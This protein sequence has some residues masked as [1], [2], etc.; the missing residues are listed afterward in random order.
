MW[1]LARAVL[2]PRGWPG[3]PSP[4][5]HPVCLRVRVLG[6]GL[7]PAFL[8]DA[9]GPGVPGLPGPRAGYGLLEYVYPTGR[10]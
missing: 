9:L 1:L 2:R 6:Q 5:L 4:R 7:G 8:F 10:H 3:F